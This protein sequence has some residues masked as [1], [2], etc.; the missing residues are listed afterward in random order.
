MHLLDA[1]LTMSRGGSTPEVGRDQLKRNPPVVP[2]DS[3]RM[4]EVTSL[5]CDNS[6]A[7][8]EKN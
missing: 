5:A 6:R 4:V 8:H 7:F 1:A 2:A 3:D